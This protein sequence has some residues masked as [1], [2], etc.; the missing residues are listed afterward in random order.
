DTGEQVV[1]Q[2]RPLEWDGT[3]LALGPQRQETA[4]RGFDG[5]DL[6]EPLVPGEWVSLHW[7]WVC[8]RLTPAQLVALRHYSGHHLRLVNERLAQRRGGRVGMSGPRIQ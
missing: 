3:R 7:G 8:D 4:I 5:V 6:I 2:S 1:V